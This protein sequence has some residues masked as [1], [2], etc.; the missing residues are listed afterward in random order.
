MTLG[1]WEKIHKPEHWKPGHSAYEVANFILYRNG[2]DKLE[3][4]VSQ[5]LGG[6]VQF[7]KITAKCGVRFDDYGKGGGRPRYHN[8]GIWGETSSGDSLFVGVDAKVNE[9]FRDPLAQ[10]WQKGTDGEKARIRQLCSRFQNGPRRISPTD[11]VRYQLMY[12]T[13][14]TVD[15]EASVSV[16]YVVVFV[17]KA[18]DPVK[19]EA[20]YDDY[21]KFICRAGGRETAR[22]V[23]GATCHRLDLLD[24]ADRHR[25][26]ITIYDYIWD[27]YIWEGD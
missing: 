16:F 4:K 12:A 26:L 2:A 19:G 1:K 13:A 20:N 17:T 5:V 23:I 9:R 24:R 18:Y 27:D 10:E 14:G 25:R 8:L 22:N 7:D 21:M 15:A 3:R 11:D 6:P